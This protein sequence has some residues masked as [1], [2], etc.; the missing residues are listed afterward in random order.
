[1]LRFWSV[2]G[3]FDRVPV[4]IGL[5]LNEGLIESV[6]NGSIDRVIVG[7]VL[8]MAPLMD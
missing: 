1:M 7:V 8:T 5:G 4:G 3:R 6:D 2:N